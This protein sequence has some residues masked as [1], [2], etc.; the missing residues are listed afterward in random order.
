MAGDSGYFQRSKM[1]GWGVGLDGRSN[2]RKGS[3]VVHA[4]RRQGVVCPETLFSLTFS[5]C[6]GAFGE[7]ETETITCVGRWGC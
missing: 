1:D 6:E 4:A 7:A 5:D 3:S 2:L